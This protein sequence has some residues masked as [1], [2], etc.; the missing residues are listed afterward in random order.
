[1]TRVRFSKEARADLQGIA[2]YIARDK[3]DAARRWMAR[4]RVKCQVLVDHPDSG[5]SRDDL[6]SHVRCTFIGSYVIFYRR[7]G[8][9]VEIVRV[10]RGDRDTRSL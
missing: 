4:V 7:S 10:I 2:R 9:L 6:G 8:G 3:P 1:M 5:E